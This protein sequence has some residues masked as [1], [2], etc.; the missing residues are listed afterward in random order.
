M[1]KS[2]S[3]STRSPPEEQGSCLPWSA[4]KSPMVRSRI[5]GVTSGTSAVAAWNAK[6]RPK[7]PSSTCSSC[8][9]FFVYRGCR[10]DDERTTA[11]RS[12]ATW[13]SCAK[14]PTS[15]SQAP[16]EV[17]DWYSAKVELSPCPT[18]WWYVDTILSVASK[19][20]QS[21]GAPHISRARCT[22]R[23]SKSRGLSPGSSMPT[24]ST[25]STSTKIRVS[26]GAP[27]AR[28]ESAASHVQ[29]AAG[30]PPCPSATSCLC[31]WALLSN[32]LEPK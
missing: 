25:P 7:Q 19:A 18:S 12:P 24:L 9:L 13:M 14:R 26:T 21:P 22:L 28:P 11:Q 5:S 1:W 4:M 15:F 30:I 3:T 16:R 20:G 32:A 31:P 10:Q 17:E 8:R 23:K 2:S 6:L 29:G 27:P